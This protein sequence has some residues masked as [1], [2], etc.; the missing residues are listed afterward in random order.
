MPLNVYVQSS[1]WAAPDSH[2]NRQNTISSRKHGS[3][4]PSGDIMHYYVWAP[5]LKS[6]S[7]PLTG[8]AE[9]Q[10][11]VFSLYGTALVDFLAK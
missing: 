5:N 10:K 2:V 3:E 4:C 8:F 7:E 6:V 9:R 11:R 1:G